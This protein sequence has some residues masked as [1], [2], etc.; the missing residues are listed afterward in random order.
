MLVGAKYNDNPLFLVPKLVVSLLLVTWFMHTS[1]ILEHIFTFLGTVANIHWSAREWSFRVTLDLFVVYLGMATAYA[2]IKLKEYGVPNLPWFPTAVKGSV[3][4]GLG[5]MAWFFWFELS[6]E[7]K[8]V[9]N[10]YHPVVSF[11]PILGFV[12][13]RNATPFLRSVNSR[14]FCF[15]GQISLETFIL[16]FHIWLAADTKG[17]LVVVPGTKW[18]YAN[19]VVTTIIFVFVSQKMSQATG[20]LTEWL[21]GKKKVAK[22]LPTTTI[23]P[24]AL[25]EPTANGEE[26]IPLLETNPTS[27]PSSDPITSFKPASWLDSLP[28]SFAQKFLDS[29]GWKL[30]AMMAFCWG[31]NLLSPRP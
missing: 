4:A 13:L 8:F 24:A 23:A 9:Y 2:Y 3:G 31:L 14:M 18:R 30:L 12:I 20:K 19:V 16:Q 29:P 7:N 25:S 28:P 6:R 17:I 10:V 26:A 5:A 22:T 1:F 27:T 11:V 15:I 21:V